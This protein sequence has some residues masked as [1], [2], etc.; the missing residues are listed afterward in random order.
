MSETCYYHPE[1]K[2]KTTCPE[3]T[4]PICDR[5]RLDGDMERCEAC[6]QFYAEGGNAAGME[7]TVPAQDGGEEFAQP[8]CTNHANLAA[9]MQCLNC[10]RPFCLSCA[11]TGYCP[12]CAPQFVNR[13]NAAQMAGATSYHEPQESYGG[14]GYGQAYDNGFGET[15]TM[16]PGFDLAGSYMDDTAPP[17]GPPRP[18]K[19][20]PANGAAPKKGAPAAKGGKKAPAKGK[21]A[22]GKG[23]GLPLGPI[24]GGVVAVAV[25][26]GG[27]YWFMSQKGGSGEDVTAKISITSP[28]AA[29]L[30]G[31][32]TI[33]VKVGS[34]DAV[35]HVE[36]M[37]DKKQWG[38]KLKEPPFESDW[39][40][41]LSSNG[42]HKVTAKVFYKGG[43]SAVD[44]HEF[45][46][47]NK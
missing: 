5:C 1:A 25:L 14:E 15:P 26:A 24:I 36:L 4:M 21:N 7:A 20:P 9:D 23:G 45:V 27:G 10:F 17:A 33:K 18:K 31:S 32:Q 37:I 44:T 13:T 19:R 6:A 30:S 38:M 39:P 8:M 12:D 16:D 2:A 41:S 28:K 43:Q 22:K 34:Q 47:E 46:V 11:S 40:T 3:C 35:D 42:K 29:K